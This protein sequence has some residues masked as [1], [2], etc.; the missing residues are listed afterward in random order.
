MKV[1]NMF[2]AAGSGKAQPLYSKVLTEEGCKEFKDLEITDK[3]YTEEGTMYLLVRAGDADEN[4]SKVIKERALHLKNW[5]D[6][7]NIK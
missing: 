4:M 6:R 2:G 3:I 1:I 5:Y 7:L